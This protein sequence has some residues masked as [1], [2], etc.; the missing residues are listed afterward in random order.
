MIGKNLNEL[1]FI[2]YA[3]FKLK[4]F[5]LK[6]AQKFLKDINFEQKNLVLSLNRLKK[7]NCISNPTRSKY[8]L[9]DPVKWFGITSSLEALEIGKK[10]Q[11]TIIEALTD[12]SG[13]LQCMV[14]YGSHAR[15][16]AT[17][18]SDFDALFVFSE[19]VSA[20]IFKTRTKALKNVEL[21][22]LTEE[23][24]NMALD[25]IRSALH[26]Y[27]A[28]SEGMIIFGNSYFL[29]V[30]NLFEK[31]RDVAIKKMR[32]FI[33]ESMEFMKRYTE[34]ER[35]DP[36]SVCYSM[37]LRMR[38]MYLIDDLLSGE[39]TPP[40]YDNIEIWAREF[41]IDKKVLKKVISTYRAVKDNT[42]ARDAPTEKELSGFMNKYFDLLVEIERRM[43][44]IWPVKKEG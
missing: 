29:K 31:S 13:L 39:Y 14:I 11:E 20:E 8:R 12:L 2:L 24:F 43:D 22:V 3:E 6:D 30:L 10:V 21:I 23:E 41:G 5:S 36:E 7:L 35:F 15:F 33:T 4:E 17:E 28:F 25:D 34:A 16:M 37:F 40:S 18:R 42:K 9:M 26:L 27:S 32:A 44:S 1:Y 38:T 19:K